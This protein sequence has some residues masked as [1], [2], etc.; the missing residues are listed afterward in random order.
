MSNRYACYDRPPFTGDVMVQNGWT[1]D[2]RRN[3]VPIPYVMARDCQ[4]DLRAADGKC[5]GC[6]H[7]GGTK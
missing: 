6:R 7:Q 2:G 5:A 1:E 4:Y 3:M